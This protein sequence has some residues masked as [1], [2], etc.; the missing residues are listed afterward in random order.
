M[1]ITRGT[2][3]CMGCGETFI[4]TYINEKP[5]TCPSCKSGNIKLVGENK[6]TMGG[7]GCGCGCAH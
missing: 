6:E 3:D 1:E 7:G 4:A 2:F 5:K